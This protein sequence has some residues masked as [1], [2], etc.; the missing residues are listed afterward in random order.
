MEEAWLGVGSLL[1]VT[2]PLRAV[3]QLECSLGIKQ[4]RLRHLMGFLFVKGEALKGLCFSLGGF[5]GPALILEMG[6]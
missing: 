6:Y 1:L 5:L 3:V 2:G 4:R